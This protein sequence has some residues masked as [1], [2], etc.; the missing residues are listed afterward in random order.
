MNEKSSYNI[1]YDAKTMLPFANDTLINDSIY[2]EKAIYLDN[3]MLKKYSEKE[4]LK[5]AIQRYAEV[6][7]LTNDIDYSKY[8]VMKIE[9]PIGVDPSKDAKLYYIKFE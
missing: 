2:S 3:T 6:C 7:G 8:K 9:T 1:L 4:Q 5:I